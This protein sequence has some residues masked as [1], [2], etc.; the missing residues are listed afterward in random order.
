M[1]PFSRPFPM[2]VASCTVCYRLSGQCFGFPQMQVLL[3]GDCGCI[4]ITYE[5]C[6]S[7]ASFSG[8]GGKALYTKASTEIPSLELFDSQRS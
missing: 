4:G 5:F 2:T 7:P 8:K 3:F 1:D 6:I